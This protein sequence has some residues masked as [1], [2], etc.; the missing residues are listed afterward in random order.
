MGWLYV[1]GA[2]DL[3]SGSVSPLEAPT[4]PSVTSSGKPMQPQSWSRAWRK[5]GWIRLLS[6][7]T[8]PPSMA[9]RGVAW[10]ILSQQAFRVSRGVLP[11]SRVG[12]GVVPIQA[13]GAFRALWDRLM[14]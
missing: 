1:P 3:S 7:T 13:E 6:G 10:S 5:G 8:L 11:G 4:A 2:E 12:S 14:C 9:A